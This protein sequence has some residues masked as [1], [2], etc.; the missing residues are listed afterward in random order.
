MK[1]FIR[2]NEEGP[3]QNLP[4]LPNIENLMITTFRS[5]VKIIE[6]KFDD[7]LRKENDEEFIYRNTS[8]IEDIFRKILEKELIQ[9]KALPLEKNNKKFIKFLKDYIPK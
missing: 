1:R 5:F 9:K 3:D 2:E 7:S 6:L 8:N 4:P